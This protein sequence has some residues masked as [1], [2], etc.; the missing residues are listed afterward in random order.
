MNRAKLGKIGQIAIPVKD[1][2]RARDFY[3][4]ALGFDFL[5]S[6]GDLNFFDA[7]GVRL[8]LS[9]PEKPEFAAMGSILYF[10]VTDI[11]KTTSEFEARGVTLEQKPH[12]VADMGSYELWMGF[13]RD[14]EGNILGLME[15]KP[16]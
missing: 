12:L 14:S 4:N 8:M 15:E 10:S 5:F 11:E 3:Q 6:A 9:P 1:S 2:A 13:I 16:K 7:A